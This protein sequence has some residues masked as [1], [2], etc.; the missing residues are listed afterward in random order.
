MFSRRVASFI[1]VV[2]KDNRMRIKNIYKS[3]FVSCFL[4]AIVYITGQTHA[5]ANTIFVPANVGFRELITGLSQPVF[6][7]NAGDGSGRLFI[8]ERAGRIRIFKNGALLPAPFLDIESIVNSTGGEEGL[9]ALA[10]HPNYGT[11]GQFYTLFTDQDGSLVLSRFTRSPSNPDLADTNSRISLLT[12]PHPVNQN[13]NGGTLAFGPDGY[14]YW[15]TGDG[16]SGGDPPN[17]AQNLSVLLGKVL[18]LDV[19]N[20]DA[21]LN[22]GIPTSNPFFGSPNLDTRKIWAYGL[23]NPWRFSFDRLTG[24]IFIGDVG[25]SAREEIDFQAAA[26]TGGENYGWRVMEGTLC[27]NPSSGCDQSG[28]VLPIID[29]DHSFGCAVTGGYIYRGSLYP[30]MQGHYFY[31]DICSGILFSLYNDPTNGWTET[32]IVDTPYAVSTFGED[33]QGELYFTDYSA[34][35]VYQMCYGPTASPSCI[36]PT[37]SG[38]V[39]AAGATI[40]YTGGTTTADAGG[41][42]SFTVPYSWS[43]TV[44]PSFAGHTFSPASRAYSNVTVNLTAQDY[45]PSRIVRHPHSDFNGDYKTDIAVF[46]PSNNTWYIRGIGSFVYGQSGDTPVAADYNGDGMA[47]IAVFRPSN[48]TWYIR[49]IGSFVYGQSGD[50]PVVADYNGDG[51]ADIAVFRPSNSTWHIRG[52]GLFV[53]GQSGDIPAVAD[54]NGDGMADIAVFR[55]SNS[56]WYIRGI[57]S[58]V[59]GQSG[60]IPVTADYNGDGKADIAVFRPT[61]STWYLYGIGPRV[62][63]TVGDVPVIGDYDGDGKADIAVFRPTN[64]TWYLY[65]IGPSVYGTVG[66]IPV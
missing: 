32:Q 49:G 29:Y 18:R 15:S 16:G 57:G 61:N 44:T 38:N 65:G 30:P 46:R 37:I 14:L 41:A 40:D 33:E 2:K 47:D 56:T 64:S 5:S 62:Y 27:Y 63:G 13:H 1:S 8:V 10:F 9:L 4:I 19:D 58:F 59:Y 39:G 66:D 52:I 55:P 17:N 26:S 12:I 28:K 54:Y 20:P 51:M 43:G 60:D 22:Y 31:S 36:P 42:Y 25:Q 45:T 53:Y 24:D 23:R 50:I 34:G 48:S 3:L 21:G 7:A 35:K 11:S 6:V